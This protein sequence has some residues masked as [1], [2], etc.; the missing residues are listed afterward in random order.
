MGADEIVFSIPAIVSISL[1]L[2]EKLQ[3][4]WKWQMNQ[5]IAL[6]PAA[7]VA[8]EIITTVVCAGIHHFIVCPGSRCA[9]LTIALAQA[10]A[11]GVIDLHVETDERVAG[12]IALGMGKA[13]KPAALVTTS[14]SAVANLH[15]AVEEAYYSAVPLCVIS[16]DRPHELRGVGASQ[17]TDQTQVLRGSL[18]MLIDLPANLSQLPAVRNH[19]RRAVRACL[20]LGFAGAGGPGP[21]QLNIAF[22]PPLHSEQP[23]DLSQFQTL[24]S[25]SAKNLSAKEDH[26]K[27]DALDI[28]FRQSALQT[29]INHKMAG[30]QKRSVVI[31]GPSSFGNDAAFAAEVGALI[32]QI[33]VL[34]EPGSALRRLPQAVCAHPE[35]LCSALGAAIERAIVIGHPTLTREVS[36]LLSQANV[37]VIV[38]DEPPS[39]TDTS[40]NAAEIINLADLGA[41]ATADLSWYRLW[42][43]A[44][45]CARRKIHAYLEQRKAERIEKTF[46][47]QRSGKEIAP[48][49]KLHQSEIAVALAASKITTFYAASSIIREVNLYGSCALQDV[50][51]NRGLAGID[52]NI[53][54][55]IGIAFAR[56]EPVRVAV[57]DLAFLHDFGALVRTIGEDRPLDLQVVVLDDGGGSLF[58]T[59]E[60]GTGDEAVFNRVF[61]TAKEFDFAHFAKALGKNVKFSEFTGDFDDLMQ[62]FAQ[63]PKGVEIVH[64][65]LQGA[66]MREIRT[67]RSQLRKLIGADL[68]AF[69]QP[70]DDLLAEK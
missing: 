53:S 12:F 60:Y 59:L 50:F 18:R 44:S 4:Y 21:V 57:G 49:Q 13:G 67:Q 8:R 23:W 10:E 41:Y 17:T 43:Q 29:P 56:R 47:V 38:V 45:L 24:A 65:D 19:V 3:T 7:A 1:R 27:H 30:V 63:A 33:P 70:L 62:F 66:S 5:E 69:A 36:Q 31:A 25:G 22:T 39:F 64:F 61:R 6:A 35:L 48:E 58:A 42:E 40:G 11:A 52:G 55:A 15:P 51:V 68:R 16:A 28:R 14:G 54:T 26:T 34:A 46:D 32:G 37:E 20:G 9:P 2:I